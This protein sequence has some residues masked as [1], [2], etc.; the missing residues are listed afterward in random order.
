MLAAFSCGF[1][2]DC[3][4]VAH[5]GFASG[6]DCAALVNEAVLPEANAAN[7]PDVLALLLP[8]AF[9]GLAGSFGAPN[10]EEVPKDDWPNADCPKEGCPKLD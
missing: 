4:A 6:V 9:V 1:W 5:T 3:E 2:S 7:P 8:N 10:A